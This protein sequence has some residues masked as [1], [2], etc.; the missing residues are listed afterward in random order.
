MNESTFFR[1]IL[2]AMITCGGTLLGIFI[3]SIFQKN[4]IKKQLISQQDNLK[5]TIENKINENNKKLLTE[6]VTD[7]RMEWIYTVRQV[8]AE[9]ISTV[10]F[11]AEKYKI[12]KE[13]EGSVPTERYRELNEYRAKLNLL[14]NFSGE[15]DKVILKLVDSIDSNLSSEKFHPLQFQ[16]DIDL[17]TKHCQ[18]YLKLEW[19]R[20]KLE[21]DNNISKE[22]M[23]SKLKEKSRDL[24]K[25]SIGSVENKNDID[26]SLKY[27]TQ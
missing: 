23:K 2:P 19:E 11:V 5:K 25:A 6:H 26:C 20:V 22:E 18:I 10:Y 7:K 14:F 9:Y 17:L 12:K 15:I 27:F 24:Y 8:L 21:S 1:Y 16:N 13:N 3:S 4:Q